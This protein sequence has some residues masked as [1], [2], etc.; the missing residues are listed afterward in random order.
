MKDHEVKNYFL[1]P[2]FNKK[3]TLL[4]FVVNVSFFG[5]YDGLA[6][7]FYMGNN[8]DQIDSKYVLMKL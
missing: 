1:T 4:N 6:R 2:F 8:R 7:L 5:F 3:K